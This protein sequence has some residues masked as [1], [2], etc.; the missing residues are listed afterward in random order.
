MHLLRVSAALLSVALQTSMRY[1][2]DFALQGLMALVWLGWT[3]AP[4]LLVFG[5]RPSLGGWSL[6]QALLVMAFFIA[7]KGIM[8]AFIQPNLQQVVEHI[9]RGTLDLLLVKPADAQLLISLGRVEPASL[10]QLLGG[11]ALAVVA[12]QRLHL[13]PQPLHI[14][15]ALALLGGATCIL[16]SVWLIAVSAAFWFVRVDNLA[17]LFEAIFDAARWPA[18]AFRGWVRAVLT[19][20]IPVLLMT[21]WP[22]MALLGQL[23]LPQIALALTLALAFLLLARLAWRTALRHYTSASS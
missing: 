5:E 10:V 21:S 2:L 15:A 22:A 9:R 13:T 23:D 4:L 3:L 14:L 7:L 20:V 17:N 11:A 16:Y 12:C 6:D 18:S 1:R 8:E 19:F